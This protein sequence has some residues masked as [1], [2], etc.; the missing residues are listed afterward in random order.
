[1]NASSTLRHNRLQY[2]AAVLRVQSGTS[3]VQYRQATASAGTTSL[4]LVPQKA[5]HSARQLLLCQG[6]LH[7]CFGGMPS[8]GQVHELC[9]RCKGVSL[10]SVGLSLNARHAASKALP[11]RS[12]P[13]LRG[14]PCTTQIQQAL[15]TITLALQL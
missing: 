15:R 3:S 5:L 13:C 6:V 9:W 7:D 14:V 8:T 10:L 12:W 11:W 2:V 1:M 4:L